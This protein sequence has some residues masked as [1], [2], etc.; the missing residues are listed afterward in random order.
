MDAD[1][2]AYIPA[3]CH[4]VRPIMPIDNIAKVTKIS[5]REISSAEFR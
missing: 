3:T 4:C 5:I 2:L 1:F